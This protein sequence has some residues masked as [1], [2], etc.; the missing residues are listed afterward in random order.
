MNNSFKN[1][2]R[3]L[4]VGNTA[5][6]ELL[7]WHLD[8]L[9]D[10]LK[11]E[12]DSRNIKTGT[13]LDIGTGHGTQANALQSLGFDV[14]GTD[15]NE[16]FLELAKAANPGVTYVYDDIL[17]TN[18]SQ[19]FDYIFDRGCFHTI[20]KKHM[21]IYASVV[22]SLVNDTFFL[23]VSSGNDWNMGV[24]QVALNMV[25]KTF[26][27]LFHIISVRESVFAKEKPLSKPKPVKCFF[28]VMQP[29]N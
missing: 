26:K 16:N 1:Q 19:K 7:P 5:D 3:N 6:L 13:F 10:D 29:I 4:N 14:T 23:K 17:R 20:H 8:Y 28:F 21:P 25:I 27:G 2:W 15:I 18:L 22:H 24:P 11:A 12:L 9:D